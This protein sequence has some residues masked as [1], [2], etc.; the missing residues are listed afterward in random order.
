L[1]GSGKLAATPSMD[2]HAPPVAVR[3]QN[4]LLASL[5]RQ[6]PE[7]D[8][9]LHY[10]TERAGTELYHEGS[11]IARVHFPT[12]G[13]VSVVVRLRNGETADVQTIGNE[14]MVGLPAWLGL[15]T[16]PDTVVQQAGGEMVWIAAGT[17]RETVQRSERASRLLDSYAAYTLR[18]GSQTCVCNAHHSVRQRLCRWLLTS[19]DRAGS[20][21]LDLTQAMLAEMIG[22]RRQSVGEV[23]VTLHRAGAI[24]QRRQRIRIDDA[25]ALE[26]LSCE[27]YRTTR[28]VYARLVE[29]LL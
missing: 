27:C 25:A 9:A 21:E 12:R 15:A 26:R 2:R 29:P 16:S 19:V 24:A 7:L 18:F 3:H 17:L 10:H 14:G 8:A 5:L 6:C 13:V 4:R 20:D 22:V 1:P 28:E 23:L 11:P